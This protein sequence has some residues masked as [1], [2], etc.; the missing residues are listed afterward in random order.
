MFVATFLSVLFITV[1]SHS[2]S[3]FPECISCDRSQD[4]IDHVVGFHQLPFAAFHH[5]NLK[6]IVWNLHKGKNKMVWDRI[7][8]SNADIMLLQEAWLVPDQVAEMQKL[9]QWLVIANYFTKGHFPTGVATG[10]RVA[11][12]NFQGFRSKGIEPFIK[13]HKAIAMTDYQWKSGNGL[14]VF[15]IHGLN[16][17]ST[18]DLINQ[19]SHVRSMAQPFKGCVVFGGDFNTLNLEKLKAI[20]SMILS[21]KFTKMKFIGDNRTKP[22]DHVY[23]KNCESHGEI[24]VSDDASDHPRIEFFVRPL[25]SK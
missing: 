1:F 18:H 8:K 14:R 20:D 23:L 5:H 10:S 21:W 3:V 22:L 4:K 11:Y 2:A 6:V 19:V 7:K 9:G 15:N 25:G 16:K 13:T 17:V 12:T 24:L